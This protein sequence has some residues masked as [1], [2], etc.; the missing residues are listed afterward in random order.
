M[1]R[2]TWKG[3][4]F[5]LNDLCEKR[6]QELK[7]RLTF[8]LILIVPK[9]RQGYIMYCDLSKDELGCVLM[10]SGRVVAYGSWQLKNHK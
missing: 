1:T 2:L 9:R 10:Q 5:E 6:F 3:V 7:R 4:K 8:A